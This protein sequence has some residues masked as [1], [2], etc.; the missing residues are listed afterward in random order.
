MPPVGPRRCLRWQ[1][2]HLKLRS[3]ALRTALASGLPCRETDYSQL[4]KPG[5][6]FLGGAED[7][8]WVCC[9]NVTSAPERLL[10]RAR[11][12]DLGDKKAGRSK[13]SWGIS[14]AL[15]RAL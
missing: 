13:Q 5:S 9:G 11:R 6:V 4:T 15:P 3:V 12:S 7:L 1:P 8:C 14:L 2:G 10:T